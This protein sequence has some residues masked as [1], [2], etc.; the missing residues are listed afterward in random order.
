MKCNLVCS[1][2]HKWFAPEPAVFIDRVC[3][4]KYIDEDGKKT[5]CRKRLHIL[6]GSRMVN[7]PK[8]KKPKRKKLLKMKR[9]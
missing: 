3:G 2:G 4:Y 7:P 6:K 1:V 5:T 9:W 8:P